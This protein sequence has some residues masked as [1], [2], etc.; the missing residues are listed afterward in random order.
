M[1][2]ATRQFTTNRVFL[3]ASFA[4]FKKSNRS[5]METNIGLNFDSYKNSI[6]FDGDFFPYYFEL[7]ISKIN[8]T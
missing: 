7:I 8:E 6:S 3:I 1:I 5:E 2:G 4:S